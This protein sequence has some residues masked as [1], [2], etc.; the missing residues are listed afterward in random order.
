M[1]LDYIYDRFT[2]EEFL[3]KIYSKRDQSALETAKAHLSNL[4]YF[5]Q[6]K[7]NLETITILSD[8]REDMERTRS[9]TKVLRFLDEFVK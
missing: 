5:C 9:P 8:L 6:D 3:E 2:R 4:D 7:H 1:A